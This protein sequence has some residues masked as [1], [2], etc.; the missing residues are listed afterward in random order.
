M[1]GK[2]DKLFVQYDVFGKQNMKIHGF[3]VSTGTV[4]LCWWKSKKKCTGIVEVR[5]LIP[6]QAWIA[7]A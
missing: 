4:V 3:L 7:A 1:I 6:V 5:V 2:L